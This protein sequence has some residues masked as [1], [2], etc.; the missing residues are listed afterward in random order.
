MAY[1]HILRQPFLEVAKKGCF[2]LHAS[3]LPYYRGASPI[4]SALA[5][6]EKQTGVSLMR[7]VPKMDTGPPCGYGKSECE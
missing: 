2:N 1:G 7:I 4:E 3:I 6:G 5:M